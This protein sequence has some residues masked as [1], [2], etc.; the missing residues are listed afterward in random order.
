[1]RALV[2]AAA[3]LLAGTAMAATAVIRGSA[4]FEGA[5]A[6]PPGST[7]EVELLDVSGADPAGERRAEV[8]VEVRRRGAV[9]FVLT[10]DPAGIDPARY[11]ELAARLVADGRTL[12][13][14]DP[15]PVLTHGA[16]NV[17]VIPM[18]SLSGP[19]AQRTGPDPD[20]LVGTWTAEEIGGAPK[21]PGV[22]SFVTVTADGN[23]RG[24][25][26]CNSFFGNYT[27]TDGVLAIGP[28]GATRRACEAPAMEQ[29][30]AFFTALEAA[31]GFRLQR[32]LLL[33]LDADGRVLAR[34]DRQ[35]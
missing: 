26:G 11:Y 3:L 14:A 6:L 2:A 35:A 8:S 18:L 31:R 29:E 17:A 25:G 20:I 30:A 23:L 28:L 5:E 19:R 12:Y 33:L 16:G 24:R 27:V 15:V 13:R 21:A 22:A 32:G 34:L 4:T 10:Y 9:P 1:M 7:L